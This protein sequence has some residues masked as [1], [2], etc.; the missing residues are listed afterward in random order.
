MS[1]TGVSLHLII[2]REHV[3]YAKPRSGP[4][5]AEDAEGQVDLLGCWRDPVRGQCRTP[6]IPGSNPFLAIN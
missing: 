3:I 2:E 5:R 1:G 4:V 6:V